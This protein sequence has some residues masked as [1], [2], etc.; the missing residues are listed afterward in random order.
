MEEE[1]AN[2]NSLYE[3]PWVRIAPY[4]LGIC[5]GYILDKKHQKIRMNMAVIICG[6]IIFVKKFIV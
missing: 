3:Q 6:K 2:F 5:L 4:L 1:L